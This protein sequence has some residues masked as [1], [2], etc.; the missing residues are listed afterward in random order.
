MKSGK[1]LILATKPFATEFRW[2]SWFFT[3]ST[4]FL[5]AGLNLIIFLA[6]P[7][8]LRLS[9][10]VMLGFLIVRMFVIYHD[11]QHHAILQNSIIAD[12]LFYLFGLYVLAPPGIWKRSHNYHHNHNSK[13]FSASIGSYPIFT[14]EKYLS[15]SRSEQKTYL[16]IRHPLTITFGYLVVFIYGMCIQSFMSKKSE[17]WDSIAALL[18]HGIFIALTAIFFGWITVALAI[19]I[20]FLIACAMGSY[21]FY[22]QHNFPEVEFKENKIEWSYD[23]AALQSSSY[24]KMNPFWQWVTANIGF[25]HI[26]HINSRIPFYRLPEAMKSLPELGTPKITTLNPR[27]IYRCFQL[28]VWDSMQRKMVWIG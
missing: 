17:H 10:S 13:L 25:H 28:K 1:E 15:C 26:H 8:A 21:L 19:F 27:D 20:P 6:F 4:L 11:Y 12:I 18:I 23:H 24:M 7:F 16:A 2:K 5:L 9:A 22:A 14:K 3:L